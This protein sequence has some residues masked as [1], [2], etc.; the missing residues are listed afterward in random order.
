MNF[1]WYSSAAAVVVMENLLAWLDPA[2]FVVASARTAS[3]GMHPRTGDRRMR[4]HPVLG[5][6]SSRLSWRMDEALRFLLF[7]ATPWAPRALAALGARHA[8]GAIL[9]AYPDAYGVA[10]ARR[11]AQTLGIPLAVYLHDAIVEG[12]QGSRI[13]RYARA[14]QERLFAEPHLFFAMS[15]GLAELLLSKHGVR[16]VPLPHCYNEAGDQPLAGSPVEPPTVLFSGMIYGINRPATARVARAAAHA[17]YRITCTQQSAA[18]AMI[19]DGVPAGSVSVEGVPGRQEYLAHLGRQAGL[20]VA[21]S[22]PDESPVHRDELATIFPTKVPEYLGT[23]RPILVHCPEDY[24]LARFFRERGCGLV[25]TE[26]S[27]EALVEA[28]LRLRDDPDLAQRLGARGRAT[29]SYFDG[30]RISAV[31]REHMEA[32]VRRGAAG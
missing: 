4:V 6:P 23:G 27:E 2:E 24:Y 22:W 28:W 17:G 9:A 5:P 7:R 10:A 26:R 15:E 16:A 32:L 20:F 12:T 31:F 11:A 19:R 1:D 25:V 21:L 8:C 13:H 29:V 14:L 3:L 30:R 18:N